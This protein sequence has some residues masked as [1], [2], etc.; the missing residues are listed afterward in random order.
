MGDLHVGYETVAPY[1]VTLMQGDLAL[2]T[3]DDPGKFFR[4]DK[5][6]FGKGK[7]R[8]TIVYNSNITITDAPLQAYDCVVNGKPAIDWVMER[9]AVRVDKDSGIVNDANDYANETVGAPPL[10]LQPAVPGHLCEP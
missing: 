3:I 9:Q 7:D 5:M 6:A 1:P 2:A 10:P 8:S 4:G